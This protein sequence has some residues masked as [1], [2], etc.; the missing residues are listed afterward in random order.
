MSRPGRLALIL[1]NTKL[2]S[3][4]L[5]KAV[6]DLGMSGNRSFPPA[7]RIYVYVVL[8]AVSFQI[9]S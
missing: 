2:L 6:L 3:N 1:L 7:C 8:L 5:T 9:A 4:Q